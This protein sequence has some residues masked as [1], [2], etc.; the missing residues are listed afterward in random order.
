MF[1]SFVL[2]FLSASFS[3]GVMNYPHKA[4]KAKPKEE[5]LSV[6]ILKNKAPKCQERFLI[7]K[8]PESGKLKI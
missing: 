3:L 7:S 8:R 4:K 5:C 6:I 2:V 1:C